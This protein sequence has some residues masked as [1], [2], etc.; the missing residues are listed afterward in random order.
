[1]DIELLKHITCL[2]RYFYTHFYSYMKKRQLPEVKAKE[3]HLLV[4]KNGQSSTKISQPQVWNTAL[5]VQLTALKATHYKKH[6]HTTPMTYKQRWDVC[7]L[8]RMTFQSQQGQPSENATLM[9][10]SRLQSISFGNET[11]WKEAVEA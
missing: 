9:S 5:Q 11:E 7:H 2:Q 10:S 4:I 8:I 1:M 6:T 3:K